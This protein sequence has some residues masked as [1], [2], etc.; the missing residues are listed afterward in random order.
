[1]TIIVDTN[2]LFSA[3]LA[4]ESRLRKIL[5]AQNHH[6]YAPNFTF[7]ELFK[8]KEKL[9]RHTKANETEVY[10]FLGQLLSNINFVAETLISS[11]CFKKAY[12]LC[13]TIDPADTPFVALAIQME[14]K[15]W[16]GDLKLLK[17]LHQQ[18]FEQTISTR[19]LDV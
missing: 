1:M 18:G 14:A 5:L 13:S 6:F 4:R 11:E 3:M 8:H 2:I 16:S 17:A 15:L 19:E 10:E 7:L 9:L 12:A